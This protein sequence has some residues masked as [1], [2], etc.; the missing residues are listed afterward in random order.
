MPEWL[1]PISPVAASRPRVAKHGAYYAGPYKRFR[2]EMA[3]LVPMI[4]GESFVPYEVPL[5]VDLEFYVTLP[6]CTKLTAPKADI[7]NFT[8]AVLDCLNGKLWDDDTIIHQVYAVKQWA[9]KNQHGYFTVGVDKLD[10]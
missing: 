3:E 9:S 1:F 6:K 5:R 2:K 8:K 4:L 7:D 10:K